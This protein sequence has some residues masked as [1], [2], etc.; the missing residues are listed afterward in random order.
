M[1][2][3]GATTWI[4]LPQHGTLQND[5]A[6]V[7]SPG[8]GAVCPSKSSFP[9]PTTGT[10]YPA[11]AAAVKAATT[12]NNINFGTLYHGLTAAEE[13]A[14]HKIVFFGE[15][16]SRPPIVAFQRMVQEAMANDQHQPQQQQQGV[17]HVVFEHFSL[18]MQHLLDDYQ[19]G[20]LSFD[21][22]V[23]HYQDIGT[24]GHDLEPYRELLEDANRMSNDNTTYRKVKL[25]A[26]FLSRTYARMLMKEGKEAAFEAAGP[27]LPPIQPDILEGTDYH[28]NIF[29]SLLTGRSLA[30]STEPD[31]RFRRIFQAQVFKDVAMSYKIN[32]LLSGAAS[33]PPQSITAGGSDNN[34]EKVSDVDEKVLVLAGNGHVL[35]Y[36]GVPERVLQQYPELAADACVLV[37]HHSVVDLPTSCIGVEDSSSLLSLEHNILQE[38][39]DSNSNL[40]DYVYVYREEPEPAPHDGQQEESS[41]SPT[42]VKQETQEAYDRVGESA[43]LKGNSAKATA[44]MTAM[45]YSDQQIA[46]AG[47]DVHNF[48]GVG[49]PHILANIQPGDTVLDVGSGLGIDSYIAYEAA[50]KSLASHEGFVLGIDISGNEVRHAQIC[51]QERKLPNIRFAQADMEQ[52]PLPDNS[53]DVVISNGAF[54][55]APDKE[56]AFAEIFRVLKPGGRISICTTTTQDE[57]KLEAGVSWPV[58]MKMFYP[59]NALV[60]LCEKLGYVDVIVDESDSSMSMELPLEV[61]ESENENPNPPSQQRNKVHVGSAEFKHLEGYDMDALCARVC[62]VARKPI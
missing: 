40:A 44:I 28:Y 29:E 55:L 57:S 52:I 3:R 58:C 18:D 47:K 41:N 8:D 7:L 12:N 2:A 59:K 17:L 43:H 39:K 11:S 24:E 5:A 61:M 48:Q 38:L 15:I 53:V 21:E 31:D 45:Y 26:G 16:H 62:V 1:G 19:A 32:A 6:L 10:R 46:I 54:C 60:P 51:A 30:S 9:R 33:A 23:H 36:S 42:A 34:E 14:R 13:I 49:N 35:G 22:L 25:H 56:K 27:W 37:S 20:K 50:T 4:P